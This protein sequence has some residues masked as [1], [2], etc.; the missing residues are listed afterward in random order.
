MTMTRRERLEIIFEHLG[1]APRA[2][3]VEEA[4]TQLSDILNDVEDLHSGIQF[5]PSSLGNDGRFYPP[6]E[7]NKRAVSSH[8]N[9]VRYRTKGHNIFIGSNGSIEIQR[10]DTSIEFSKLGVDGRDI[11]SQ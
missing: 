10:L 1:K 9:V 7:D 4:L 2:S 5:D 6:Q 11:W 8:S 3:S